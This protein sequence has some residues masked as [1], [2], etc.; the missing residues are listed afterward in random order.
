MLGQRF[1]SLWGAVF[2][3]AAKAISDALFEKVDQLHPR[4]A[5]LTEENAVSL[6]AVLTLSQWQLALPRICPV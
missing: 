4:S 6:S 3:V 5:G 2:T 1:F